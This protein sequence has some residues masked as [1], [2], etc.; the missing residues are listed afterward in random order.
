MMVALINQWH[1][2]AIP[3]PSGENI[4]ICQKRRQ[5]TNQ[6][7]GKSAGGRRMAALFGVAV[8]T[9]GIQTND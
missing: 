1:L 3:S 7:K 8:L 2:A 5:K 9:G 4:K 6:A